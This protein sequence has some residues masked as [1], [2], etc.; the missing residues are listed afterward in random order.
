MCRQEQWRQR[1]EP[2][3]KLGLD[4][5]RRVVWDSCSQGQ[6]ELKGGKISTLQSRTKSVALVL[7][8][9]FILY[10]H[11]QKKHAI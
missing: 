6:G 3:V 1:E 5:P 11:E 10:W 4:A 2:E 8:F 9:E 7:V